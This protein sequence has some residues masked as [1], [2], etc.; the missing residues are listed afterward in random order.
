MRKWLSTAGSTL[1][2]LVTGICLAGVLLT[3]LFHMLAVSLQARA[4]ADSWLEVQQTARHALDSMVRDIQFSDAI[5]AVSPEKISFRK[6]LFGEDHI[7]YWLDRSAA[8]AVIRRN[9]NAGINQPL[10]GGGS[11][12]T[13]SV[14]QLQFAVLRVDAAGQ[15]LTVGIQLTVTD[16][17]IG[18]PEKRPAF[19]LVTAVTGMNI[20]R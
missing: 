7:S 18:S 19:T 13:I 15:P 5:L 10:T 6:R 16:L 8:A 2:E 3:A 12:T 11:K 20:R 9:Q 4:Q 14:S 1:I 17:A